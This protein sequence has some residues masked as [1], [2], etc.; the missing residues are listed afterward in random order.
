MPRTK[1]DKHLNQLNKDL[2]E[3]VKKDDLVLTQSLIKKGANVNARSSHWFFPNWTVL[4]YAAWKG[5][6][7]SARVLLEHGADIHAKNNKGRTALMVAAKNDYLNFAKVLIQK[8]ARVNETDRKGQTALI[9]AAWK[10]HLSFIKFLM[11]HGGKVSIRDNKGRTA[12][13]LAFY[14]SLL[15][16]ATS[17][18]RYG[19]SIRMNKTVQFLRK[20]GTTKDYIAK[21]KEKNKCKRCKTKITNLE[22]KSCPYCNVK[23]PLNSLHPFL[24]LL[25]AVGFIL[26]FIFLIVIEVLGWFK[27]DGLQILIDFILKKP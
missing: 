27:I 15:D 19:P 16:S 11:E 17:G 23:N 18:R 8:G 9:H 12:S 3:A 22:V 1:R 26:A 13:R 7:K 6:L 10:G 5:H 4:M 24:S 25:I 20:V 21:Q 14:S 2:F